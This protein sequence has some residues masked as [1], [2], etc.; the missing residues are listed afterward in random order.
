MKDPLLL[1]QTWKGDAGA[2]GNR[3]RD[4][5]R[6]GPEGANE[7]AGRG[8]ARVRACQPRGLAA[9]SRW[10]CAAHWRAEGIVKRP[11]ACGAANLRLRTNFHPGM[12]SG[13]FPILRN[14]HDLLK[15]R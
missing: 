1:L 9:L 3:H 4:G 15:I 2:A 14:M 11:C 8:G 10:F 6:E 13:H 12:I 7:A 5:R